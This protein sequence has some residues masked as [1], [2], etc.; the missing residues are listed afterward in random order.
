MSNMWQI[1]SEEPV[2]GRNLRYRNILYNHTVKI[3]VGWNRHLQMKTRFRYK[4]YVP[5]Q[6][7]LYTTFPYF[8]L[9]FCEIQ[10]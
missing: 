1:V 8:L 5:D 6:F 3:H 9:R 7:L 10:Y 4:N 2:P